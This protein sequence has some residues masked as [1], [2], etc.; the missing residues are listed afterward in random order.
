MKRCEVTSL[1]IVQEASDEF[2]AWLARQPEETQELS[3]LEQ[4]EI[5]ADQP[6]KEGRE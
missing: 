6:R 3:L 4:I 2:D 5:Y 1:E